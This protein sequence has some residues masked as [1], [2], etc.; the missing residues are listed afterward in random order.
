MPHAQLGDSYLPARQRALVTVA[1]AKRKTN[2]NFSARFAPS[3][4]TSAGY[5]PKEGGVAQ[6]GVWLDAAFATRACAKFW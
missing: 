3:T 2:A 4:E 1:S 6:L 5:R